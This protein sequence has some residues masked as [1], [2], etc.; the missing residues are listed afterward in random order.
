MTVKPI[1]RRCLLRAAPILLAAPAIAR[2]AV[3]REPITFTVLRGGSPIGTHRVEFPRGGDDPVVEI[4]IDL[5]VRLI[6]LTVYSYA[7]RSREEWAGGM[8]RR[9]DSR[10][11][12]NGTRTEVRARAVDGG[13]AVEGSGG[14]YLAPA[15][16]RPTSYWFE[17]MTQHSR[18]LNTQDGTLSDVAARPAGT[19]QATIAGSPLEIRVYELTGDINSR[20]GYSRNGDWV[21]LEF[22]ARGS[23]IRYRRDRMPGSTG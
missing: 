16:T 1:A 22:A 23:T 12:D 19:E 3:P 6:G 21:D 5:A 9:L 7:H 18:L 20:I 14:A 11:D 2:T 4:A 13:L 10:T 17:E 8:L 15:A